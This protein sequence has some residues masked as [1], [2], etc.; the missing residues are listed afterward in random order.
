MYI[1]KKTQ[2]KTDSPRHT[3]QWDS[4]GIQSLCQLDCGFPWQ[5]SPGQSRCGEK[6]PF[7]P[8]QEDGLARHMARQM[9]SFHSKDHKKDGERLL[10]PGD[11]KTHTENTENSSTAH[12]E[13]P[14]TD[15]KLKTKVKLTEPTLHNALSL[16]NVLVVTDTQTGNSHFTHQTFVYAVKETP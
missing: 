6:W 8:W 11:W 13:G 3:Q 4:T 15:F 9:F 7:C 12:V 1:K 2:R 10:V 16:M 5:Q 14:S